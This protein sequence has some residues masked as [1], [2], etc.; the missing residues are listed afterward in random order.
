MNLRKKLKDE[1]GAIGTV[2]MLVILALVIGI[3]VSVKGKLEG[4][5]K[6]KGNDIKAALKKS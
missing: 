4:G 1:S 2:E 5:F 3:A 6:S